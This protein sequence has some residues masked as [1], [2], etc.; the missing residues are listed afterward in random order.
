MSNNAGSMLDLNDLAKQLPVAKVGIMDGKSREM[1]VEVEPGSMITSISM[2]TDMVLESRGTPLSF[3]FSAY[4]ES[5]VY[6]RVMQINGKLTRELNQVAVPNFFFPVLASLGRFE[7][8]L[9]MME[10]VPESSNPVPMSPE[11]MMRSSFELRSKG[12][13]C[14]LGL[15]RV[16][17]ITADDVYRVS[18]SPEG[19]L[20]CAGE[21]V[22]N[23]TLLIRTAVRVEF[24]KE[25]FGPARTR[26]L[27]VNDASR[28]WETI[29]LST[30]I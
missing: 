18:E 8:P 13:K 22:S 24:L 26:Y 29:V 14:S 23:A 10:I 15:P 28:T 27:N 9:R 19:E 30:L 2:A 3:S 16:T 6:Y 1:K 4:L 5:L 25:F 7:D 11:E 21:Q 12:V 17:L 20:A